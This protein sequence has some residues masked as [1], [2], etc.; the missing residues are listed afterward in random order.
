MDWPFV[1]SRPAEMG[2]EDAFFEVS[3]DAAKG[4]ASALCELCKKWLFIL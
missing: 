3:A 4:A 2:V 1:K